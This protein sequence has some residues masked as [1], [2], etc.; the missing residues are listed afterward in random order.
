MPAAVNG[1]KECTKCGETKPVS[2]YNKRKKNSDGLCYQCRACISSSRKK[3]YQEHG[4]AVYEAN[5]EDILK[6]KREHYEANKEDI[7]KQRK[8]SYSQSNYYIRNREKI[9]T[10]VKEYQ[11]EKGREF[12]NK[13]RRKRRAIAAAAVYKI[14]NKITNKIYIGQSTVYLERF[15]RHK[16][17]MRRGAHRNPFV[18]ADCDE[19]GIESFEFSIIQEY[20][21]NTSREILFEHEQRLIDQYLAEGKEVYNINRGN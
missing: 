2:E 13:S 12:F 20:P 4:K 19:Y 21:A 17:R 5:K 6:R 9:K 18:Q 3:Y 14:Q 8:R 7:L 16:A 15:K 11:K 1:L 10:R